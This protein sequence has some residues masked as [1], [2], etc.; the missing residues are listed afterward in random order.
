MTSRRLN[1]VR[2]AI[3]IRCGGLRCAGRL[4]DCRWSGG[5]RSISRPADLEAG[6]G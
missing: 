3:G 5:G 6:T 4:L 2:F 1:W